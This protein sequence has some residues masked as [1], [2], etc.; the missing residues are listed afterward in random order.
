MTTK[1]VWNLCIQIPNPPKTTKGSQNNLIF[2]WNRMGDFCLS[3][4][5][6]KTRPVIDG[7]EKCIVM[8]SGS[9]L[10]KNKNSWNH[11]IDIGN[12]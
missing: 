6:Y 12:H 3:L 11:N 7:A 2:N 8:V 9:T 5:T 1:F 4:H 10:Y